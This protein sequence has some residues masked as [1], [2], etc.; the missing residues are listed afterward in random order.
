MTRL[1]FWEECWTMQTLSSHRRLSQLTSLLFKLGLVS[2]L[3]PPLRPPI[4]LAESRT[5]FT[6]CLLPIINSDRFE[7]AYSS[8]GCQSLFSTPKSP[9]SSN[10]TKLFSQLRLKSKGKSRSSGIATA[11]SSEAKAAADWTSGGDD[12]N[13]DGSHPSVHSL[14]GVGNEDDSSR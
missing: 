7:Y 5:H 2:P 8:C 11:A 3:L 6:A 12:A 4:H 9:S 1:C 10:P 13:K 14:P